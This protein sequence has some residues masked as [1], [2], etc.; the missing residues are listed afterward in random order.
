MPGGRDTRFESLTA[1]HGIMT[2]RY[3]CFPVNPDEG[4][5]ADNRGVNI[6]S[7]RWWKLYSDTENIFRI[8][9]SGFG[10]RV[11]YS[12]TKQNI[13]ILW[14]WPFRGI[15][16]SMHKL[17]IAIMYRGQSI[18]IGCAQ[19]TGV[20]SVGWIA[21]CFSHFSSKCGTLKGAK[22]ESNPCLT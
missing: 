2:L 22:G 21:L 18:N 10:E 19:L 13:W 6:C 17:M 16:D 15:V 11:W 1:R 4:W 12:P 14:F 3:Y 7:V 8:V 9:I 5:F 20:S